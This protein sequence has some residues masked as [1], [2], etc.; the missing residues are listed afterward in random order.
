MNEPLWTERSS[1]NP[2]LFDADY[3]TFEG[4]TSRSIYLIEIALP[5]LIGM[6]GYG[7][8]LSSDLSTHTTG[9]LLIIVSIFCILFPTVRRLHDV[10]WS[11]W[12]VLVGFV[13]GGNFVLGLMLLIQKGTEGP[14]FYGPDPL[15]SEKFQVTEE[16]LF[17]ESWDSHKQTSHGDP[18][19]RSWLDQGFHHV[20]F[21]E[22]GRAAHIFAE[23]VERRVPQIDEAHFRLGQVRALQGHHNRAVLDYTDALQC[24]EWPA[25][26]YFRG[27]SQ[28]LSGNVAEAKRDWRRAAKVNAGGILEENIDLSRIDGPR[29][30]LEQ[31]ARSH[32]YSSLGLSL[33]EIHKSEAEEVRN[34]DATQVENSIDATMERPPEEPDEK[35]EKRRWYYSDWEAHF[36]P[37]SED[38]LRS[39]AQ[40]GEVARD[41][42]VWTEGM[43]DWQP[44]REIFDDLTI[45]PPIP[46]KDD[47]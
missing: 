10:N 3:F 42:L 32:I 22:L 24:Q 35:D 20:R 41:H 25:I 34:T 30:S 40:G 29:S 9:Y 17:E 8:S 28:A 5:F 47:R 38:E 1:R 18:P 13:P 15:S 6:V 2:G 46:P 45:P 14:N 33:A 27:L 36:G 16:A 43:E 44:V 39:K 11:G 7:L 23:A 31:N 4:R 26:L 12:W 37:I 21:G 19:S